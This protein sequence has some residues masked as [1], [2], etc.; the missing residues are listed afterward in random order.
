MCSH[1]LRLQP[2]KR[3]CGTRSITAR[4]LLFKEESSLQGSVSTLF[5]AARKPF[6]VVLPQAGL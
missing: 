3:S 1:K 5:R 4:E 6:L 2:H